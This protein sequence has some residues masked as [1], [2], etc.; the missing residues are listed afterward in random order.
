M[1]GASKIQGIPHVRGE[2]KRQKR[3]RDASNPIS[4]A[5]YPEG[6]PNFGYAMVCGNLKCPN[7]RGVF[8]STRK[9]QKFCSASCRK[10]AWFDAHFIRRPDAV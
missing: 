2:E 7:K 9:G 1:T 4:A 6:A 5:L 3:R 10:T 8:V